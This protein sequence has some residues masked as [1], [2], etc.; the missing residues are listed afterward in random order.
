MKT[1]HPVVMGGILMRKDNKQDIAEAEIN[2][3]N[4][5]EIV[6]VNLYPFPEVVLDDKISLETKIENNIDMK[7]K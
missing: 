5:I 6:C 3:I 7:Y 1:L 4:P 2:N